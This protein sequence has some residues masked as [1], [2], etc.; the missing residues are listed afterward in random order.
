[1]SLIADLDLITIRI[2]DLDEG[3]DRC[4]LAAQNFSAGVLHFPDQLA[5]VFGIGEAKAK[6]IYGPLLSS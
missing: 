4:E 2:G 5:D 1:M 3:K 6:M